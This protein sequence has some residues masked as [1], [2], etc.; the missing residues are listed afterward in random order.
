V[1]GKAAWRCWHP[2]NKGIK[3]KKEKE[4]SNKHRSKKASY[5]ACK[6]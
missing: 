4:R 6:L 5:F 1:L 3:T 2:R